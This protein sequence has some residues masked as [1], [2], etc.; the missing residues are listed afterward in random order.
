VLVRPAAMG[1]GN[2]LC[3]LESREMYRQA[4]MGLA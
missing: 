3:V 1:A 2:L 4:Q